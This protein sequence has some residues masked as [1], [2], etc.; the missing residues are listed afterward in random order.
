MRQKLKLFAKKHRV[1]VNSLTQYAS[2]AIFKNV[3]CLTKIFVYFTFLE[4]GLRKLKYTL[5]A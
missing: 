5:R 2:A 1:S 4:K 3:I